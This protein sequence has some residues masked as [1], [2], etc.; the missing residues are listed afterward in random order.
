[1]KNEVKMKTQEHVEKIKKCDFKD[2]CGH[3]DSELCVKK[4]ESALS[5]LNNNSTTSP[6]EHIVNILLK[7]G[8]EAVTKAYH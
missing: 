3:E 8:S 7:R 6:E 5:V 2:N 1:M 4:T